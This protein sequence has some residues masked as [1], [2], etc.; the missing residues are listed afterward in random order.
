[1]AEND[2]KITNEPAIHSTHCPRCGKMV[3]DSYITVSEDTM[4]EYTRCMLGQRSFSKTIELLGGVLKLTFVALSAEQAELVKNLASDMSIEEILDLK[5]LATLS[6]IE[7]V[8]STIH[9]TIDKYV[10]EYADR[11]GYCKKF[12]KDITKVITDVDAPMLGI[13]RKCALS[14]DVLCSAIKD[15]IFN[16]DFYEGIGLL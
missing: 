12:P 11:L 7:V 14:F 5:L 8:D 15:N 6:K 10:A 16:Q 9:E 2:E 3:E 13:I 1:M 4:Q